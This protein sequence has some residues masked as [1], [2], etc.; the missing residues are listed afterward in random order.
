MLTRKAPQGSGRWILQWLRPHKV[1]FKVH[2]AVS[3]DIGFLNHLGDLPGG[4]LLSQESLHGL[5][6]LY[7]G[8]LPIPVGVKLNGSRRGSGQQCRSDSSSVYG[9]LAV[10]QEFS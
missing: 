6:Q 5:L 8:D 4:E 1:T 7:Q 2:G 3:V 10:S 9:S